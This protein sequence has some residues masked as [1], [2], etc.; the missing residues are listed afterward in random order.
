MGPSIGGLIV[1]L[2]EPTVAYVV[3]GFVLMVNFWLLRGLPVMF[4]RGAISSTGGPL[5]SIVEGFKF[6]RGKPVIFAGLLVVGVNNFFSF[7]FES[8]APAFARDVYGAGPM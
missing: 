1:K 5:S 7:P 2:I 6:A 3:I 8:M 4:R